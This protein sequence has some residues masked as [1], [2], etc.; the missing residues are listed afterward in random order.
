MIL[1]GDDH[2]H[3]HDEDEDDDQHPTLYSV[4]PTNLFSFTGSQI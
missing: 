1:N 2:D 4:L 3:D